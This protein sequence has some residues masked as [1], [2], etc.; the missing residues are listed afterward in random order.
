MSKHRIIYPAL[1][2][3]GGVNTPYHADHSCHTA[4]AG[5]SLSQG[6]SKSQEFVAE[7]LQC[8]LHLFLQFCRLSTKVLMFSEKCWEE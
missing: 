6:D 1:H 7:P 2:L 4:P 5:L 8:V 3:K